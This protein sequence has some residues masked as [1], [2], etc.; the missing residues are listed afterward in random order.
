MYDGLRVYFKRFLISKWIESQNY[1]WWILWSDTREKLSYF[2]DLIW[3]SLIQDS[4]VLLKETV[5]F[6]N[7]P[8][9]DSKSLLSF[10]KNESV[11]KN[12]V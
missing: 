2:K 12:R 8:I 4:P 10:I 9:F 3:P 5:N 7:S 6:N 1:W 11:H